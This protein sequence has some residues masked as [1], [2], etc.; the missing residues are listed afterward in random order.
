MF[1][2][3]FKKNLRIVRARPLK[4]KVNVAVGKLLPSPQTKLVKIVRSQ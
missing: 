1:S 3:T 4:D 2:Q